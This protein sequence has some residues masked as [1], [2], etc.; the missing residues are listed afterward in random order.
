MDWDEDIE[1]PE[2]DKL[3]IDKVDEDVVA[4]VV[5]EMVP[6]AKSRVR[7]FPCDQAFILCSW[8]SLNMKYGKFYR[9]IFAYEML[10]YISIALLGFI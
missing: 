2:E 1:D 6:V 3:L 10:S 8:K 7:S 4:S 5:Q 9:N